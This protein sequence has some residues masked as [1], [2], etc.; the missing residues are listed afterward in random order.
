MS[1]K[2][3]ERNINGSNS[4]KSAQPSSTNVKSVRASSKFKKS[5]QGKK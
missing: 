1:D 2:I 4:L 5:R 3:I